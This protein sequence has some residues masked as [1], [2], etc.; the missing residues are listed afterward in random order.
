MTAKRRAF[1]LVE[2]IAAVAVTAVLCGLCLSFVTMASSQRT[3]LARRQTATE[4]ATNAMERLSAVSWD[5]LTAE[6]ARQAALSEVGKE[7]LPEGRL[8]AVVEDAPGEP[9]GRRVSVTVYWSDDRRTEQQ[10]GLVA[11]RFQ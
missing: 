10:V 11:W 5:E 8:D 9:A 6:R 3:E 2:M 7:M 1:S 4:E